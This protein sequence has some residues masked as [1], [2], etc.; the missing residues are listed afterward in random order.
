MS[1]KLAPHVSDP[2][3]RLHTRLNAGGAPRYWQQKISAAVEQVPDLENYG[4]WTNAV[5]KAKPELRRSNQWDSLADVL[6]Q[7]TP[8]NDDIEP[9]RPA[10]EH[11]KRPADIQPLNR[12]STAKPSLEPT[13]EGKTARRQYPNSSVNSLNASTSKQAAFSKSPTISDSNLRRLAKLTHAAEH[14]LVES[15]QTT[16]DKRRKSAP[17]SLAKSARKG[18]ASGGDKT[19]SAPNRL[20]NELSLSPREKAW[21]AR[22]CQRTANLL[23]RQADKALVDQDNSAKVSVPRI[24]REAVGQFASQLKSPIGPPALSNQDLRNYTKVNKSAHSEDR[25]AKAHPDTAQNPELSS[26]SG[27]TSG[28]QDSRFIK[29]ASQP[30]NHSL[31]NKNGSQMAQDNGDRHAGNRINNG[32]QAMPTVITDDSKSSRESN[33]HKNDAVEPPQAATTLEPLIAPQGKSPTAIGAAFVRSGSLQEQLDSA[34]DLHGLAANLKRI[35]D[36]EAR[37]HGIDV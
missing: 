11:R 10:S 29:T 30:S 34:E 23:Q 35:L 19:H 28:H 31:P 8:T 25:N 15:R 18:A 24:T 1:I 5:A 32:K 9:R 2:V 22:L 4:W 6:R 12:T 17:H 27:A 37:R 20:P 26:G 33:S 16:F 36:A 21:S 7:S 14:N 3:T 13:V